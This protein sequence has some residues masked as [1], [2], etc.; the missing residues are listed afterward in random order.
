MQQHDQNDNQIKSNH[1]YIY[2]LFSIWSSMV[3]IWSKNASSANYV[4]NCL[5]FIFFVPYL[6][7]SISL[8]F[9][10]FLFFEPHLY[11]NHH[12]YPV[13]E[14]ALFYIY[15][16]DIRFLVFNYHLILLFFLIKMLICIHCTTNYWIAKNI[17]QP[18]F[19]CGIVASSMCLNF[20]DNWID[21][22]ERQKK[23]IRKQKLYKHAYLSFSEPENEIVYSI[24][25]FKKYRASR[26]AFFSPA[27]IL[28][29]IGLLATLGTF[30]MH[31]EMW[32]WVQF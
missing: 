24:G 21:F 27:T 6:L 8:L 12:T 20:I 3:R 2:T 18:K 17:I 14:Y 11:I 16:Y 15:E 4:L 32:G 5:Q 28:T 30:S 10:L 22:C 9:T 25:F 31:L 23:V 19:F 26:G 13:N 7:L 29:L 1:A